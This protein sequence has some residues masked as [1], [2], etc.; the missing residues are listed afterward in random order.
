MKHFRY[1]HYLLRH[2]WFV[3]IA[4]RWMGVSFW[5]LLIHDWSKFTPAEWGAYASRFFGA[6]A[7]EKIA[8]RERFERAWLHHIHHNPH[9]W[10]HWV[11]SAPAP[12]GIQRR[13]MEMPEKFAR[14]MV[15]DWL[16]AG[17]AITGKW[18]VVEWYESRKGGIELRPATR[19]LVEQLLI[20]RSWQRMKP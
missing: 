12:G 3:F 15:A 8:A 4:G 2:K 1:L 5:R 7:E 17:R 6:T 10:E 11:W 9:H 18:D 20:S 16:G 19:Q 14:E 13:T